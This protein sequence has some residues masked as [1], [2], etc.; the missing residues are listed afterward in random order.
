MPRL[1]NWAIEV[2]AGGNPVLTG[3]VYGHPVGRHIDGKFV[4]TSVLRNMD[5]KNKKA[6]TLNTEYELG[7]ISAQWKSYIDS[8]GYTLE[9]YEDA[10]NSEIG[11]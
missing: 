4:R 9:A 7:D 6:N 10:I 1:E 11:Q 3:N 8:N 5:L 2:S